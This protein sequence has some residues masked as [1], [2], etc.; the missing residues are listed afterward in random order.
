MN[1][2]ITINTATVR[3]FD[4]VPTVHT[5]SDSIKLYQKAKDIYQRSS[6]SYQK[7]K[8]IYERCKTALGSKD[9][10]CYQINTTI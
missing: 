7:A 5:C 8:D 2:N 4:K 1:K 9:V 10:N 6:E 3:L